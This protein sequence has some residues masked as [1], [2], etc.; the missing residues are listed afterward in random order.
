[1]RERQEPKVPMSK[2]TGQDRC[3]VLLEQHRK[4]LFKVAHCYCRNPADREDLVQE[5]SLQIWRSFGRYDDRQRFQTWMYRVALNVAISFFRSETR[6]AR[7]ALPGDPILEIAV[8]APEST[9]LEDDLRLLRSFIEQLDGLD[10]ALIILY[11]DGNRYETIGGILG[12]SETSVGTRISRIKQRL[13]RDWAD[14]QNGE[15][16]AWNSMT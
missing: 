3:L 6:R 4:I 1:M 12:I 8:A 13:R 15:D 2:P 10:R 9:G 14:H 16:A 7:I 11:L 5:M